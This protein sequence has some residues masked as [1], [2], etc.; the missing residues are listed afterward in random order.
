MGDRDRPFDDPR[1]RSLGEGLRL[2]SALFTS[3]GVRLPVGLAPRRGLLP[4]T[5]LLRKFDLGGRAGVLS[6]SS[7]PSSPAALCASGSSSASANASTGLKS[8]APGGASPAV[9]IGGD[10]IGDVVLDDD[11]EWNGETSGSL[12]S[13]GVGGW[14][15]KRG[16]ARGATGIAPRPGDMCSSRKAMIAAGISSLPSSELS[17]TD[18]PRKVSMDCRGV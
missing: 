5:G 18:P 14:K 4:T 11:S 16:G 2:G 8:D 9:L 10:C 6:S 13:A 1:G 3:D 12:I 17:A 7:E 15:V